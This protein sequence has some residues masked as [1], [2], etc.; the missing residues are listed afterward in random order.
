MVYINTPKGEM[1]KILDSTYDFIVKFNGN[2]KEIAEM[3]E[4]KLP[5][6]GVNYSKDRL[7]WK[8]RIDLREKFDR[9][10]KQ[11]LAKTFQR[12]LF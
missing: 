4:E 3:L 12:S 8:I 9:L 11:H 2:E 10:I 5:M 6:I 1:M 7:T